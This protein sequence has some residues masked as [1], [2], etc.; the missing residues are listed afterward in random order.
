VIGTVGGGLTKTGAGKLTLSATNTYSGATT[1]SAG[2]LR[3][4][5]AG[6]LGG[7]T[8]A[9]SGGTLE[10]AANTATD[11]TRNT[12]VSGS[13]TIK[14]DRLATG[15]GVT[16]ILGTLSIGAQTLTI[17][18][19]SNV[20][21]GTAGL[22]FSGLTTLSGAAI[23]TVNTGASL[24]LSSVQSGANLITIG[25]AGDTTLGSVLTG[26]TG[27]L[28][29]SGTGT[30][31]L[32]GSATHLYTG[33]T[34]IT[35]GVVKI[36]FAGSGTTS[37]AFGTS[38]GIS[39]AV[40][41]SSGATLDLN[42]ISMGNQTKRFVIR[43]TGYAS[44]GG[45]LINSSTT[46]AQI[47][48]A[49]ILGADATIL[50][51]NAITLTSSNSLRWLDLNGYNLTLSGTSA[52]GL[53]NN[54]IFGTSGTTVTK[55]GT[56]TWTL[57]PMNN[58]TAFV[59]AQG[60]GYT[61]TTGTAGADSVAVV[62]DSS[63]ASML[64]ALN[65]T[66]GTI[67]L[68]NVG[69]LPAGTVTVS[70]SGATGGS[71]DL[72]GITVTATP[73]LN[74]NGGNSTDGALRNSSG[75]VAKF[76]GAVVL[77]ANSLI[78][79]AAS[80]GH[81]Y[82]SG[83]IS[84]NY[85][86]SLASGG[87]NRAISFIGAS[88][89]TFGSLSLG[90]GDVNFTSANQLGTGT[91][92][93]TSSG[94]R[95]VLKAGNSTTQ[96]NASDVAVQISNV[97]ATGSAGS[98]LA[99]TPGAT[100]GTTN[101]SIELTGKISGSG[102][103]KISGSAAADRA[104]DGIL[105][106]NNSANDYTGTTE[107]GN[108]ILRVAND[109]SLGNG[110]SVLFTTSDHSTL[111]Y[112]DN[113]SAVSRGFVIG[114][115]AGG[116]T[117]I[118]RISVATGKAVTISGVISNSDNSTAIGALAKTGTGTL[119][120]SG[121]NTYTGSTW[122]SAGTLN[123]SSGGSIASS[124]VTVE[125]GGTLKATNSVNPTT[126]Q[127]GTLTLNSNS[128][129]DLSV[130]GLKT[131]ALTVGALSGAEATTI[132]FGLNKTLSV[133]DFTLNGNLA[134][135]LSGTP[136]VAGDIDLFSWSGTSTTN[137]FSVS[138]ATANTASW[139]YVLSAGTSKYTLGI[140]AAFASGGNIAPGNTI[141][142][143]SGHAIGTLS[144]GTA[145]IS[146]NNTAITDYTG[147]NI[148]LSS[149]AK[150]EVKKGT[151]AGVISGT[152]SLQKTTADTLTLTS[153]NTY[154]GKTEIN[155]GTLSVSSKNGSGIIDG[156][157]SNAAV[158]LGSGANNGKLSVAATGAATLDKNISALSTDRT[159][160]GNV[161][162]NSGTGLLT[163]TGSLTKNGTV[164][165]LA[166]GTDGMKV[167]GNIIGAD[168]GSDLIVSSGVVTVS[169][170]NSYNGPTFVQNTATLIA[171]NASATG[172]GIVNVASGATLQVGTSTN[173]ALT[174]STGG[175]AL[176]NGAIIRVYVG[177]V[178]TTGLTANAGAAGFDT[179]YTHFDLTDDAGTDYSTLVTGTLNVTGVTA[180]GITIQ[181][182]STDA[183]NGTT[184]L[185]KAPFYDFKFLQATTVTGLG[186]GLNIASLFTIDTSNLKYE[187]GTTVTGA[188]YAGQNI[189]GLIKMYSVTTGGN[190]VLMMSIPEPSTYGL[191]LGAL[192]LAVVAIRRRKQKKS[193][194]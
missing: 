126:A 120:L 170:S 77:Q 187:D 113:N 61:G 181:V 71:L 72:N 21:S 18:K 16:Q 124:N 151:S 163:V 64:G 55:S 14:S 149:S 82:L 56:G 52:S 57:T 60:S 114:S 173:Y 118:G 140:T 70:G 150:V 13:S 35:N 112:T 29:K 110:G 102:G 76:D 106:I 111:E 54:S 165:T 101:N 169:S 5:T 148:E 65:I 146:A 97:L 147:G 177:S 133:T 22:S 156:L 109:A 6:A 193:V 95:L 117:K 186:T 190:T 37:S 45:A 49:V 17:D 183:I 171:D 91:I 20:D 123:I 44:L 7:G 12:T 178:D 136:T 167:T 73:T 48:G 41:L 28:T 4:T 66:A 180:G 121:V 63:N 96:T 87:T 2:V 85:A 137:G 62:T 176:T 99:F 141:P 166:G 159:G 164:L 160:T 84:G 53:I 93:T 47:Y 104:N 175:F 75:S 1:L 189:A 24:N 92:T 86:L 51:D 42:G 115:T 36:N 188:K 107:A 58:T 9:I 131:G 154:T 103:I 83:V 89:N 161:L 98:V 3:A 184:G 8:L 185:E 162:E 94:A 157:G 116:T 34:S 144:G 194:A 11:F 100:V 74:L 119:N 10:L 174:L 139:N 43:G 32:S 158:D 108:G 33:V 138:L 80:G 142:V 38:S 78:T 168:S 40:Y 143:P 31:T 19:G 145:Q 23:F 135:A 69:A 153:A 90:N 81:L 125:T 122:V 88:A 192:A 130:G 25:G 59:K 155:Q 26:S 134:F 46:S 68:G 27:G 128:N 50:A 15:A 30:L 172:A 191:G 105:I 152:G 39:S 129:V 79:T 182:Y 67:K 127:I 132:T 179:N